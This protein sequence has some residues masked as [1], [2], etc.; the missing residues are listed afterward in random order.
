MI[1]LK[2]DR[3][4]N[5][6]KVVTQR[7]VE[8]GPLAGPSRDQEETKLEP[9]WDQVEPDLELIRDQV[10][11]ESGLSWA[12]AGLKSKSG[13]KSLQEQAT[14]LR[15][16]TGDHIVTELMAFVGR[17]NHIKF[18]TLVLA[19]LLALDMVEMP[20][21]EKPN[22]SKQRYRLTIAGRVRKNV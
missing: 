17:N 22:S 14:L 19:P 2:D 20:I 8:S 9:N 13:D 15:R 10:E 5:Q 6:F 11:A 7:T 1:T 12:H 21:P 3:Q 16:V 4:S 18:R